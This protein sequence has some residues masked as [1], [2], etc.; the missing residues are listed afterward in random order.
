MSTKGNDQNAVA[1][2][3]ADLEAVDASLAKLTAAPPADGA[4]MPADGPIAETRALL[5]AAIIKLESAKPAAAEAATGKRRVKIKAVG[6]T[7]AP[8]EA[9]K[10]TGKSGSRRKQTEPPP[11]PPVSSLLAR[12]G[13]AVV[14]QAPEPPAATTAPTLP[15]IS[16]VVPSADGGISAEDAGDRLA[17]LEAEIEILTRPP[18]VAAGS[19]AAVS[20]RDLTK[21][22][23]VEADGVRSAAAA[24]PQGQASRSSIPDAEYDDDD[25]IEV[26]IVGG[27]ADARGRASA[28]DRRPP[29][30][31]RHAGPTDDAD[32]EIVSHGKT[33]GGARS[34]PQQNERLRID[35]T[36]PNAPAKGTAPSRWRL[37]RGSR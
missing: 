4:P 30:I 2:A 32:V 26:T 9:G 14:P 1:R 35:P 10:A 11:E 24:Q 27:K 31:L 3:I 19:V 12:L 34:A 16:E 33:P 23:T 22:A 15:E 8:T 7:A 36:S 20:A 29:R 13:A 37:F 5:R 28:S 6:D 25:D 17:R 18:A 21:G